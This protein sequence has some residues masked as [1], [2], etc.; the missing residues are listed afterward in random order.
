MAEKITV[1]ISP[2]VANYVRPGTSVELK[3][4]S[5]SESRLMSAT[6]RLTL[7]ICLAKDAAP[8]IRDTA[9]SYL[10]EMP[11]AIIE[12][13]LATTEPNPLVMRALSHFCANYPL[14]VSQPEATAGTDEN[15]T[16]GDSDEVAS[17][18]EDGVVN[19]ESAA[20]QSKY[21]LARSMAIADKIKMAL[22]GD[23]EWR[24]ILI[25]D[26]NKLIS[27]SVMRNPR[28]SEPEVLSIVKSG[29]QN[30]EVIRLICANREWIKN[31]SI[32]KALIENS[33]TPVRNALTYL[34]TM[35]EKD[36]AS[37]A[38][39]KNIPTVIAAMAKRLLLNKKR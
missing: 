15:H 29:I 24:S 13:Y 10:K 27:G 17:P 18:E 39:S 5:F 4:A 6:D 22:T 21:N 36:L 14:P 32:R 8:A 19:E 12:E 1:F 28:I 31:Y 30:D 25:I 7:L 11:K 35:G 38:K 37:Y 9:H 33:R 3:Q 20:F 2:V 16:S 26:A 23:K 34:G